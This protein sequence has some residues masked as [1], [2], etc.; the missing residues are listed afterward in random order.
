MCNAFG[1]AARE[2]GSFF[3]RGTRVTV[4]TN[5]F[6]WVCWLCFSTAKVLHVNMAKNGLSQV[7]G[8]SC[9][10]FLQALKLRYTFLPNL[11]DLTEERGDCYFLNLVPHQLGCV[12]LCARVKSTP[13]SVKNSEKPKTAMMLQLLKVQYKTVIVAIL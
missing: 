13:K 9:S 7:V 8:I 2:S 12:P 4:E 6:A 11:C 5:K 3:V 10:G 1:Y